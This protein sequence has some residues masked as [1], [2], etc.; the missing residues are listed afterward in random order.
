M[1]SNAF[2]Q[3]AQG[4]KF[5][6]AGLCQH[7]ACIKHFFFGTVACGIQRITDGIAQAIGDFSQAM[8]VVIG[9]GNKTVIR[10][11][12]A[13]DLPDTVILVVGRFRADNTGYQSLTV[14]IGQGRREAIGIDQDFRLAMCVIACNVGDMTECVGNTHYL[15]A[16]TKVTA[17]TILIRRV[18]VDGRDITDIG[19][20]AIL[21]TL[22]NHAWY[23]RMIDIAGVPTAGF[24]TYCVTNAKQRDIA[25]AIVIDCGFT[26]CFCD[27]YR[28]AEIQVPVGQGFAL[29]SIGS[30]C[31]INQV[32]GA[33]AASSQTF[34]T[35]NL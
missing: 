26:T 9:I 34:N 32:A 6:A 35:R 10:E 24:I 8:S 1:C 22:S 5:L 16:T 31:I 18:V 23:S 15:C 4:I 3:T 21:N 25:I 17:Q 29:V 7:I 14:I 27:T 33:R 19:T 2:P 11:R 13:C 28:Q 12:D 30:W 20:W